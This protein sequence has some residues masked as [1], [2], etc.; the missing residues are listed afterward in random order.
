MDIGSL[1]VYACLFLALYFEVFLLITFFEK[2][3]SKKTALLPKR[4]PT[5]SMV[6]PCFNG[7]RPWP[8]LLHR[9]SI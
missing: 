1:G 6:V 9:S 4:Y 2:Q 7:V 3:P 5:V 8:Q